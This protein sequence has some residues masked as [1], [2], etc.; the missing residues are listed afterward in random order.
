MSGFTTPTYKEGGILVSDENVLI[1]LFEKLVT[2]KNKKY[3][4]D[5]LQRLADTLKKTNRRYYNTS[6]FITKGKNKSII[7]W[8]DFHYW[9][10]NCG[11]YDEDSV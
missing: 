11:G 8:I 5:F 10:D 6:I 9:E 4:C 3:F 2:A 1:K 7:K